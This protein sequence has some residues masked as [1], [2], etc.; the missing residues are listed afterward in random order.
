MAHVRDWLRPALMLAPF[1][2]VAIV[3]TGATPT[4]AA[5]SDTVSV[6]TTTLSTATL[7]PPTSLTV[8][9]S[10]VADPTPVL[11]SGGT[12]FTSGNTSGTLT[13]TKPAGVVAGDVMV[14]GITWFGNHSSTS[15]TPPSGWTLI[16]RD[17]DNTIGQ[18]SYYR[19]ATSSQA[20]SWTWTGQATNA[21]GGIAAYS[22]VD[23]ANP[24]NASGGEVDSIQG[25]EI[26]PSITTTR[27][28]V[29]LVAIFGLVNQTTMTP[30]P[31]MS[32]VWSGASSAAGIAANQQVTSLAAQESWPTTGAT[33][34][35]T[36]TASG[37]RSAGQL[38]ALQP[39]ARPYAT[40]TWTPSTSTFA[41][42]QTFTRESGATVQ[43]QA[44]LPAST[45]SQTDG[46]L[47]SGTA[48]SVS[49]F[50]KFSNW[51]SATASVTFNAR[52]C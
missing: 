52:N 5:W 34:T 48:Y 13:L 43:R 46:P 4:L 2:A 37:A 12:S 40:S 24:V 22:G 44:N 42:G 6:S 8:S 33:G 49:V 9:Q 11:R 32:Q 1:V 10:C 50:A 17:G 36:A 51:I 35:R 16:R 26:A 28:N 31:S 47:T 45:A 3:G 18:F 41:T 38:I 29:L 23:A 14:A 7:A 30:P 39:P 15:P 25:Q 27:E 20:N 21:A 19:V